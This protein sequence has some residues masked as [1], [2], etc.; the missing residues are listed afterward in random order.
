MI[1]LLLLGEDEI[2]ASSDTEI[3]LSRTNELV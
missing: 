3:A 1:V 2:T